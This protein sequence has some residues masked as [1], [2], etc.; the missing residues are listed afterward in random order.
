VRRSAL[1]ARDATNV[2]N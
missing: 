1:P 2:S